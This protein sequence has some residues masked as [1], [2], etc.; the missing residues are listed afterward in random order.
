MKKFSICSILLIGLMIMGGT[1]WAWNTTDHVKAAPNGKGDLII[2]PWYYTVPGGWDTK[3]TVINTSSTYSTVAKLVVR[4]HNWSEELIDFLIYLSPNDVWTG[5]IT[6]QAGATY[7]FSDDDS[8]LWRSPGAVVAE[9]DFANTSTPMDFPLFPVSCTTPVAAA[10]S[11]NYGYVEIIEAAATTGLTK[12]SGTNRVAKT[13]IYNWYAALTAIAPLDTPNIL[14][15]YQE[16]L[17]TTSGAY[18][19]LTRAE[20]FADWNNITKLDVSVVTGLTEPSRNTI[21]ELE[22]AMSKFDVALPYI[23]AANGDYS[24]HIFNFPTKLSWEESTCALY[25]AFND[26]PYFN[27]YGT[28]CEEYTPNIYDLKENTPTTTGLPISGGDNPANAQMC[29]EVEIVF[30]NYVTSVFREGWVRYNWAHTFNAKT[31]LTKSGS[32]TTNTFT[33]TP[34]L[35]GVM[36]LKARAFTQAPAAWDNGVVT[37]GGVIY[38]YFQYSQYAIIPPS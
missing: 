16:F 14:T 26:S 4:S 17:N 11:T 32:P 5:F 28:K 31:F 20:V 7:I 36:Y 35:P 22:A 10:D 23:N 8:V 38:P 9:A 12:I 24:V 29:Q 21:G 18:D 33:G 13:T 15:G 2:I 37:E 6:T 1:A 3:L 19:A 30:T 27:S 34:V 25:N